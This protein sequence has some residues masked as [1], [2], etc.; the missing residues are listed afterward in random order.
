LRG[1]GVV[2]AAAQFQRW[3]AHILLEFFMD[4][5]IVLRVAALVA[6]ASIPVAIF[7]AGRAIAKAQ[8]SKSAQDA[9]NEYNKLVLANPDNLRVAR[10]YLCPPEFAAAAAEDKDQ[11]GD[12]MRKAYLA[13]VILNTFSAF[14]SGAKHGL[15]DKSLERAVKDDLL[16]PLLK[17]QHIFELSQNRDYH[18]AFRKY[19]RQLH[20]QQLSQSRSMD[21]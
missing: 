10:K 16:T 15:V 9:W 12:L 18:P 19:C 2:R 4:L 6:Q 5:D 1:F 8:Y 17:D 20:E 21:S 11:E 3:A 13:F 7:F 14:H